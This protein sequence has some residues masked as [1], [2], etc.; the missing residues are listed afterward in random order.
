M[1]S[2][3][4]L[5]QSVLL[6]KVFSHFTFV[7]VAALGRLEHGG[8]AERQEEEPDEDG[9]V[10]RLLEHLQEVLLPGVHHGDV[11]VDGNHGEEGDAGSP[12]QKQHEEHGFADGI[13]VAPPLS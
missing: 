12:V 7:A 11:A 1:N 2:R 4:Y 5:N 3:F 9:D 8:N 13:V 10:W 6:F